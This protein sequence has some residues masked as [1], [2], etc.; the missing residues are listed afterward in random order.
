MLP[1]QFSSYIFQ[2]TEVD[3]HMR[4]Y[5]SVYNGRHGWEERGLFLTSVKIICCIRNRTMPHQVIAVL[6][7]IK[8]FK[9]STIHIKLYFFLSEKNVKRNF[10]YA[11]GKWYPDGR[12]VIRCLVAGLSPRRNGFD[13]RWIHVGLREDRG[14]LGQAFLRVLRFS[15]SV[16]LSNPAYSYTLTYLLTYSVVQSHSWEANWFAASQEIS[17]ISRNPK[18]H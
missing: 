8:T 11:Y 4:K 12:A 2:A 7:N 10:F 17:C 1:R 15:L 3:I 9:C 16:L 13:F 5:E 6:M 18:V 14:A